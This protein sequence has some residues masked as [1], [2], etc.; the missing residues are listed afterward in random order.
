MESRHRSIVQRLWERRGEDEWID[1]ENNNGW[2]MSTRKLH[3][4]IMTNASHFSVFL[5]FSFYFYSSSLDQVRIRHIWWFVV[6]FPKGRS[7]GRESLISRFMHSLGK[8]VINIT[9][10]MPIVPQCQTCPSPGKSFTNPCRGRKNFFSLFFLAQCKE[11]FVI[12]S[13]W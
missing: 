13:T 5:N 9:K 11:W 3:F 4:I 8:S 1:I 2:K 6:S 10:W 7:R 12:D